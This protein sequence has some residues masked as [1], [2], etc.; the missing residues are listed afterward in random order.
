MYSEP[1]MVKPFNVLR[2]ILRILS[3]LKMED[4]K[5]AGVPK[6]LNEH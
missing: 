6:I 3:R 1:Y 2:N 4:I 5:V